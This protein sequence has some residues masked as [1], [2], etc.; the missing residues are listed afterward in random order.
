M[1]NK[2][3]EVDAEAFFK[4]VQGTLYLDYYVSSPEPIP[5]EGQAV[6]EWQDVRCI[7]VAKMVVDYATKQTHYYLLQGKQPDKPLTPGQKVAYLG[8]DGAVCPYCQT[9][10]SM[11]RGS[12]VH[13]GSPCTIK[14]LAVCDSCGGKVTEIYTLTNV[15]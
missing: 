13:R 4:F 10:D 1:S 15:E 12:Y 14:Q 6:M 8:A 9:E 11:A 3:I 5:L 7:V 2:L